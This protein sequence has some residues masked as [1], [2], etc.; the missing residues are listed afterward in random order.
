MIDEFDSIQ[1]LYNRVLPSLIIRVRE[2]KSNQFDI[3]EL[4]IWNYL[5]NTKWM[6]GSN[7]MLF[8]I[9]DDILNVELRKIIKYKNEE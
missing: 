7:L 4:D 3:S 2:A 6:N 5:V 1:D 9:V 8:D